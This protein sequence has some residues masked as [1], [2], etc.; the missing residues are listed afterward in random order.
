MSKHQDRITAE[1]AI[2][3]GEAVPDI[4]AEK[5]AQA[6]AAEAI[7][8]AEPVQPKH[9]L[10]RVALA[11]VA[12]AALMG[13]GYWGH[14]YWTVGRFQISTDDAYVKADSTTIAPK[15]SGYIGEVLVRDNEP[16]KAGQVL[17]RIDDRDFAVALDQAKADVAA[18]RAAVTSKQA[19]LDAQQSVID[20][21]RATIE[22]DKANQ[23]FAEQ[24][25][26]RYTNLAR[27]G[28]GSVQNQQSAQAR[29]DAA[30]AATARDT[31][32]LAA[33]QKQVD[34]IK[35]DLAQA[36]ATVAHDEAVQ[37]QAELNLSYT[38]IT[39]PVDGTVGNRTLR[40]GQYVQAGTQ[41]MAVVPLA[42]TYI[43]GNFKETQLT[44]VKPG[45]KVE[46][47]VDMFPGVT[48]AGHVDSIAPAS[49]QE[50]A[51][52]PPDNATGNFT[53]V[54]QRVPVKIALDSG[55]AL[56]GDLRPGMSVVPTINTKVSN[57]KVAADVR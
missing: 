5:L 57:E 18:A 45:Q 47:E 46:V 14:D 54:V 20:T 23:T 52:L 7:A 36:Q 51:L 53:K 41:L 49:G 40:L 39:A 31:A 16:V 34:L 8:A 38:L 26:D 33:A 48:V 37:R 44:D 2:P 25:N 21:A 55:H 27:T 28:Y 56:A 30:R 43:V 12:V 22:V 17:A 13:A 4:V 29:I 11:G 3:P 32:A 10:R 9:T 42:G 50:F 1:R 35:A 6:I 15:I 19:Q 24:D